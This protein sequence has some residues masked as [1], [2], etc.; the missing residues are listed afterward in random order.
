M[1]NIIL[2]GVMRAELMECSPSHHR[3]ADM[4]TKFK[5]VA[6]PAFIVFLMVKYPFIIK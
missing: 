6:K 2:R 4:H 5:E 1:P 3:N